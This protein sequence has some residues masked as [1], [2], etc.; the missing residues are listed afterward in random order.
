MNAGAFY[1]MVISSAQ[2]PRAFLLLIEEINNLPEGMPGPGG[3]QVRRETGEQPPGR[4]PV[5]GEAEYQEAESELAGSE[6]RE[7]EVTR[8]HCTQPRTHTHAYCPGPE[9]PSV[10]PVHA[11]H[12]P[13]EI[14]ERLSTPAPRVCP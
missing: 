1:C 4:T 11:G 2:A 6:P 9:R 8:V 14:R 7:R 12:T 13:Q 5:D 3:R 10:E